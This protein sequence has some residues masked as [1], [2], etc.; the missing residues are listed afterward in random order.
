MNSPITTLHVVSHSK[1][2]QADGNKGAGNG[3]N[4]DR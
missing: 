2:D 4:N 3:N 1:D